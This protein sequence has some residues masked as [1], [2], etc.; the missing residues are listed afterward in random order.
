VG[1]AMKKLYPDFSPSAFSGCSTFLSVVEKSGAFR[2]QKNPK[3][4][5]EIA[6]A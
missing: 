5:D 3:G 6:L 2:I 4:G 1:S